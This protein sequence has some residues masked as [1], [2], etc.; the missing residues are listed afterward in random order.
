MQTT[1]TLPVT[2]ARTTLRGL[3]MDDLPAYSEMH[4]RPDVAR[5]AES[6]AALIADVG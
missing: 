5:R 1:M 6:A 4:A 3:T 2:L